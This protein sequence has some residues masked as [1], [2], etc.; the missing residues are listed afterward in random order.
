MRPEEFLDSGQRL[1]MGLA[2]ALG[3]ER[4]GDTQRSGRS[5][6]EADTDGDLLVFLGE[7]YVGDEQR[8]HPFALA[9]VDSR[10]VPHGWKVLCECTDPLLCGVVEGRSIGLALPFD[11]LPDFLK[12]A[13]LL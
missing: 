5:P 2:L 10:V 6:A 13:K 7:G 11:A 9:V 1:G 8:H 4:N 3:I 12:S